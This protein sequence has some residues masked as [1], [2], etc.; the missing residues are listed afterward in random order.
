MFNKKPLIKGLLVAAIIA[1][2]YGFYQA[3]K[4]K[5]NTLMDELTRRAIHSL[6]EK[7]M[8]L[9]EAREAEEKMRTLKENYPT[10]KDLFEEL[11]GNYSV[12]AFAICH[13]L[14]THSLCGWELDGDIR[15]FQKGYQE[16]D[17]ENVLDFSL[18]ENDFEKFSLRFI[19]LITQKSYLP[20][21]GSWGA[22]S[23]IKKLSKDPDSPL[24]KK[25]LI[26]NSPQLLSG[27]SSSNKAFSN[28][29]TEASVSGQASFLSI[30]FYALQTEFFP[31]R[32]MMKTADGIMKSPIY[33]LRLRK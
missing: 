2:S 17:S 24:P 18:S 28:I 29:V 13:Q 30:G 11:K 4:I 12:K 19:T 3:S 16:F 14:K 22:V 9:K 20:I 10:P 1:S 33:Y 25:E 15:H 6:R 8:S 27:G 7:K 31:D 32:L 21:R 5:K 23:F 26:F